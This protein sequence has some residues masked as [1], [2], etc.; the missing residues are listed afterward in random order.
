MSSKSKPSNTAPSKPFDKPTPCQS[1]DFIRKGD[2][3]EIY[4]SGSLDFGYLGGMYDAGTGLIYM[5]VGR[6]Y[7]PAMG[8]FLT[9]GA[10][11][12]QSNPYKPGAFD[13]AG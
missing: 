12:G 13:P 7:D 8:L 2:T 3:L 5:G 11:Q 4:G 10:N 9:R 6:Y 1:G